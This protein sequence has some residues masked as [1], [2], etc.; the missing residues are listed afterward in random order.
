MK[1]LTRIVLSTLF[2]ATQISAMAQDVVPAYNTYQSVPFVVD[3]KSGLTA[4]LVAYLNAKLK[5]KHVLELQSMPRERLNQTVINS[6]DF[7]GVVLFLSPAFVGDADKKKFSWTPAIMQDGNEVIS[8]TNKKVE[9]SSPDAFKGASFVGIRGNKYAGLED[10][11][12]KDIKRTDTNTELMSLAMVAVER[13]D[14]TIMA[15]SIY[16]YLLK[17][18]GVSDGLNNKLHASATPHSKFDRF[19]FVA[20]NNSALAKDLSEIASGMPADPAWKAILGK[21]G[22]K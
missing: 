7:K 11:F 1:F 21:Y 15:G 3:A 17:V 22:I 20:N 19:M 8:S 18:N 12:G 9:Y 16:S 2:F 6:A 10:K 5:G 13:A 4:D 14:F